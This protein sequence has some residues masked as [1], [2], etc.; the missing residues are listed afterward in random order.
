MVEVLGRYPGPEPIGM[1]RK[2]DIPIYKVDVIL[3]YL[4]TYIYSAGWINTLSWRVMRL[5]AL[6]FEVIYIK[7]IIQ[8]HRR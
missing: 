1:S 4:Y 7:H 8:H 6:R 2:H 3:F 5:V